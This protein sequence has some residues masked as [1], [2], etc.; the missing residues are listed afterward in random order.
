MR[1][2]SFFGFLTKYVKQ[3]SYSGSNSIFK[4]AHEAE[5]KN[6]RLY[7]PLFLYALFAGKVNIFLSATKN[8]KRHSE[9]KE[10]VKYNKD[11]MQTSQE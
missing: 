8:V 9:F 11:D 3:L 10:L 2:L 4:L 6:A 7:E 1:V 5:N